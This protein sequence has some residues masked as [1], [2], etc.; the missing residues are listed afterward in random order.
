MRGGKISISY[1]GLGSL[2]VRQTFR[3]QP[4]KFEKTEPAWWDIALFGN[5]AI[6]AAGVIGF[7][8]I[9]GL[10]YYVLR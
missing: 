1:L 8:L 4:N 5:N 2:C 9:A 6:I 3:D 10:G 7:L